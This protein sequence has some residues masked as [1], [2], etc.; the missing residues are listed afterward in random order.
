MICVT[1]GSSGDALAVR[2][3]VG[4]QSID[5]S[6]SVFADATTYDGGHSVA[7]EKIGSDFIT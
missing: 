3:A 2:C 6:E 5:I 4:L 7:R 1:I